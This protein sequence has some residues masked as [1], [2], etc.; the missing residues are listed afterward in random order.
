MGARI[1]LKPTIVREIKDL[2]AKRLCCSEIAQ[3][4]GLKE[5]GVRRYAKDYGITLVKGSPGGPSHKR[6]VAIERRQKT[7]KKLLQEGWTQ[8][9]IAK[10]LGVST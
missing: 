4:L 8:R 10:K 7:V 6:L 5:S 9:A 1:A 2:A 3:Q